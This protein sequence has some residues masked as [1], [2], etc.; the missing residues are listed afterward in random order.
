[1]IGM[2]ETHGFLVFA[3]LWLA[4]V[5]FA[6]LPLDAQYPVL[7]GGIALFFWTVAWQALRRR[8]KVQRGRR[9]P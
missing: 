5:A 7:F 9:L 3:A 1:M 8:R 4:A 2:N 6:A